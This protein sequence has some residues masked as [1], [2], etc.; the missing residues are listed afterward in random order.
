MAQGTCRERGRAV[1]PGRPDGTSVKAR[2]VATWKD[3]DT[4]PHE[5]RMTAA[6]EQE[7]R[8]EIEPYIG[9]NTLKIRRLDGGYSL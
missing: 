4:G 7:V 1:R 9:N 8:D 6:S 3:D 2:F 5:V